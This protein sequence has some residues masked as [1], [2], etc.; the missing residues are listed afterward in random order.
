MSA[1]IHPSSVQHTSSYIFAN[2]SLVSSY[3][4]PIN[5]SIGRKRGSLPIHPSSWNTPL[6]PHHLFIE[7]DRGFP[8]H[9]THTYAIDGY[10]GSS[11]TSPPPY[12]FRP[13]G[14]LTS[15]G[16]IFAKTSLSLPRPRYF[17]TYLISSLQYFTVTHTSGSDYINSQS[18]ICTLVVVNS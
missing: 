17:P 15:R 14:T 6:Y 1:T 7:S 18:L 8:I 9:K 2:Q 12:I 10:V 11:L 3:L 13:P 16:F 5:F 4:S